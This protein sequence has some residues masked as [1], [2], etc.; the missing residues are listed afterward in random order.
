MADSTSR[1][2]LEVIRPSFDGRYRWTLSEGRNGGTLQ[3]TLVDP[4]YLKL[5]DD[6][7]ERFGKGD[8]LEVELRSKTRETASG[9]RT[10]HEIVHVIRHHPAEHR[11]MLLPGSRD[12]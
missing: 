2:A 9:L 4:N 8:V 11:Q 7:L 12:E 5:L 6:N 3:A 1:R 10:D